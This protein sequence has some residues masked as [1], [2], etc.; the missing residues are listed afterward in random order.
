RQNLFDHPLGPNTGETSFQPAGGEMIFHLPNGLQAYMLV[1]AQGRRIDKAPGEIVADPR[2]P[3]QRVQT[4]ISCKSCHAPGLL[5]KADQV[6]AHVEKSAQVFANSIVA[7]VRTLHPRQAR[8][9]AQLEEDN[10]RYLKALEPFGVRDPDQ[11]PVNLVTQ[12]FEATLDGRT[13]AAE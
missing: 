11:E 9:K 7:A 6:R 13:A 12:R 1:D 8:F 10:F 4:G 5:F 2:R 3:D